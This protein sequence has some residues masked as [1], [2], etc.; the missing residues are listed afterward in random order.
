MSDIIIPERYYVLLE[1]LCW[2]V[3]AFFVKNT[4]FLA[5]FG[6]NVKTGGAI[7]NDDDFGLPARRSD[8]LDMETTCLKSCSISTALQAIYLERRPIFVCVAKQAFSAVGVGIRPK[9]F[10]PIWGDAE[11]RGA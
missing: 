2:P 9:A 6:V 3:G 5:R 11:G 7:N 1:W 10:L 8:G 4:A